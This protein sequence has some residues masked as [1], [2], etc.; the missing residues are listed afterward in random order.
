MTTIVTCSGLSNTGKLTTQVAV[1]L[2]RYNPGTLEWVRAAAEPER[3][4]EATSGADR[5]LVL[6]GCTDCCATK[7]LLGLGIVPDAEVTATDLGV[8]KNGMADPAYAEIELVVQTIKEIL[9]MRRDT[10]VDE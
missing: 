10:S 5:V 7:K 8:V 3:I 2:I 6:N 4:Q 1:T 9:H